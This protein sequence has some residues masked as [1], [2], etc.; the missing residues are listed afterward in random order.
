[1]DRGSRLQRH[2]ALKELQI[3]PHCGKIISILQ[4]PNQPRFA[5]LKDQKL[6]ILIAW[7]EIINIVLRRENNVILETSLLNF[8]NICFFR[9]SNLQQGVKT[10]YGESATTS[11][12]PHLSPQVTVLIQFYLTVPSLAPAPPFLSIF[13][14][15]CNFRAA[16]RRETY[17][18][19]TGTLRAN[20]KKLFKNNFY[21]QG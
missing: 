16:S 7:D 12:L 18:A 4:S 10:V 11:G 21:L 8:V 14:H 2:H 19:L 17:I 5:R 9:E 15:W 3:S 20:F 13:C 6:I 1:M